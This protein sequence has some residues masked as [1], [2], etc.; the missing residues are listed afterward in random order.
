MQGKFCISDTATIRIRK[1]KDK[2][3]KN[4]EYIRPLSLYNF[5]TKSENVN[6][7]LYFERHDY[8]KKQFA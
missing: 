1:M 8:L 4:L 2:L 6:M 3:K 7:N 5:I